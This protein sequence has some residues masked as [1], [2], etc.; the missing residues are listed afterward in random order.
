MCA[1][2]FYSVKDPAGDSLHYYWND[3]VH[4]VNMWAVRTPPSQS[5]RMY[6]R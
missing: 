6:G 5:P 2:D 4:V 1:V 3:D